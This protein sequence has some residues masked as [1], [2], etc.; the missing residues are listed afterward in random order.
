M[1]SLEYYKAEILPILNRYNVKKAA[2]FGSIVKE[3]FNEE[4]DIDLLVELPG[5]MSL[6]DLIDLKHAI[7]DHIHRKVDLGEFAAIKKQLKDHILDEQV[8]II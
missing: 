3:T 8:A 5:D 1:K 6:L 7:E 2:F 4:S